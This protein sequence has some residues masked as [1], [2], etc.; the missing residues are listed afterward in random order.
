M[1]S[2]QL[3]I[4]L[5]CADTV[6]DQLPTLATASSLLHLHTGI[7]STPALF[8]FFNLVC[9]RCPERHWLTSKNRHT[10]S[11][12]HK[13]E[14]DKNS[15]WSLDG[16]PVLGTTLML[17]RA[18]NETNLCRVALYLSTQ[19]QQLGL[20]QGIYPS[21]GFTNLSSTTHLRLT[22]EYRSDAIA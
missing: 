14:V 19:P 11:S 8:S 1:G 16:L 22:T 20:N 6:Y 3:H 21:P 2:A 15:D 12:D 17:P 13:C 9:C 7:H 5:Y 10:L 4:S 18:Y